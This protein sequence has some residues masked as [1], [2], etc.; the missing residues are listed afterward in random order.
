MVERRVGMLMLH[1]GTPRDR[2]A[3]ERLAAA[4]PEA[5][6]GEPDDAGVFEAVVHADDVEEALQRIW[7]AVAASGADDHILFLEHP[8]LPEHWR[9]RSGTPGGLPGS[10]G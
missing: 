7:D 3:R 9:S 10:L 2:E 8:E 6:I 1:A 5:Q 4:L